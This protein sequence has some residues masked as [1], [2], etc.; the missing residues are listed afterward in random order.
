MYCIK[1][2][3]FIAFIVLV[4]GLI[5]CT[6]NEIG[7]SKDVAQEKIYQ[8]YYITHAEGNNYAE[9]TCQYRFGGKNGTTLVLNN[10]SQ[11]S[12]DGEKLAV[13]SNDVRG[14]FYKIVKPLTTFYGKHNIAFTNID[15]KNYENGFSFDSF[16]VIIPAMA[17]ANKAL[18][19]KFETSSLNPDDYIEIRTTDSDS[20]F[21]ISHYG[22]DAG[23][24]I[25][26]PAEEMKRQ[27]AKTIELEATLF[28]SIPLQQNTTEGGKM[29]LTYSLK[30]TKVKL[31]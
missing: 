31:Q 30:P 27:K 7:E 24:L 26:I 18:E 28:K 14:A 8:E 11:V 3:M 17:N 20:S 12:F 10:P 5:A 19:I 21:A 2:K 23:N 13:D 22:K 4:F 9:V 6:S 25:V 29:E 1:N 16:R 15:K